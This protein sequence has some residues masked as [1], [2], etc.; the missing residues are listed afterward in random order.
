MINISF[1]QLKR[2]RD[3]I[4][5]KIGIFIDDYKLTTIYRRKIRDFMEKH[6]FGSFDSFYSTLIGNKSPQLLQELYNTLTI[7]ETYFFREKEQLEILVKEILPSVISK[8]RSVENINILSAPCSTGEEV[9][10]IA[11]YL[12]EHGFM[13]NPKKITI[14]G[15]DIDS[16]AVKQAEKGFY[17]QKSMRNVPDY[18]KEK[19]F[20]KQKNG[21]QVIPELTEAVS[22]KVVN[23]LNKYEMQKLGR[24]EIIFSRNMLIYFEERLRNETLATFYSILKPEGY[25]FLGHAERIPPSL[26]LFKEINTGKSVVYQKS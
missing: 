26:S 15:I 23:V 6:G 18:I 22:F 8:K 20:I 3:F 25:L 2:L 21:Y 24:F 13:D 10:T 5:I 7:N 14:L 19:Y 9:Y 17:T 11:I 4:Q 1:E 16:N 12:M